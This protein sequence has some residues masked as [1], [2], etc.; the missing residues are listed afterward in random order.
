MDWGRSKKEK[1]NLLTSLT[2]DHGP[3][4]G[5]RWMISV[6]KFTEQPKIIE[7]LYLLRI[8]H[9]PNNFGWSMRHLALYPF[10]SF[11]LI[12]F[13]DRIEQDECE[14]PMPNAVFGFEWDKGGVRNSIAFPRYG[15]V[16]SVYN[17]S[18]FSSLSPYGVLYSY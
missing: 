2:I 9:V 13:T 8:G 17:C 11:H 4:N 15:N 14:T 5:D 16:G 6:I 7:C 18:Y 3:L 1:R 12:P 10:H